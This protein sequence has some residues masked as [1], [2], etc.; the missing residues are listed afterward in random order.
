MDYERVCPRCG[1]RIIEQSE[2][3]QNFCPT[4]GQKLPDVHKPDTSEIETSI[5]MIQSNLQDVTNQIAVFE[6]EYESNY[7]LVK[8]SFLNKKSSIDLSYNDNEV[9]YYAD[10]KDKSKPQ[11]QR[12][13]I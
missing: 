6:Q 7:K 9:I 4:C 11:V 3:T 1:A 8:N 13:G 2:L 5:N 10:R 12:K